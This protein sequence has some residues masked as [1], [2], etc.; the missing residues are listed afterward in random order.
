MLAEFDP[1]IQEHV[2]CITNKEAQSY[3]PDYKIQ[4]EL[5]RMLSAAI[6]SK[7]VKK[8]KKI[9]YFSIILDCTP[10]ASHQEQMSLIIRYVDSTSKSDLH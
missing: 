5:I 2:R 6:Q 9:K 8:I 4:N 10:D 7:I 1:I 3:Y